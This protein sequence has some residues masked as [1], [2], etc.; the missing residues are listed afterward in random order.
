MKNFNIYIILIV[1]VLSFQ[2]LEAQLYPKDYDD[3]DFTFDSLYSVKYQAFQRSKDS[4]SL[5]NLYADLE[6]KINSASNSNELIITNSTIHSLP[7]G[8][9]KLSKVEKVVFANCKKL[10]VEKVIEQLS[11]LKQLKS[12]SFDNCALYSL[13]SNIVKLEALE[14]LNIPGNKIVKLPEAIKSL[15]KLHTLDVS[16]STIINED[17]L[18]A[19]VVDMPNLKQLSA[20]YCNIRSIPKLERNIILDHLN[21]SGNLLTSLPLNLKVKH[22]DIS[23]NAYLEVGETL[24]VLA[25]NSGL[26]SLNL[27][28]NK[29][30]S[31]PINIGKLKNLKSLN[32]RGNNLTSLPEEIGNLTSLEELK[33]DNPD[34]FVRTNQLTSLPAS[35]SKLVKLERLYLSGNQISSLPANFGKLAQLS[36]LGISWKAFQRP[37]WN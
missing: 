37:Y 10:D 31:L 29:W 30:E 16:K 3:I 21:L 12:L 19:L 24:D 9:D 36:Y 2:S 22:L 6:S 35:I 20:N 27:S 14:V 32:L 5:H 4:I 25:T 11:A 13:P 15:S 28:Y 34:M 23:A 26:E 17:F 1:T 8:I 33:V 7:L 18:F